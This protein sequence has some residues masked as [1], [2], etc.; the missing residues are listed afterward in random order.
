[1]YTKTESE[2]LED[3][4]NGRLATIEETKYTVTFNSDGGTLIDSQKVIKGEKA[5]EPTI[6]IKEG[7][8]FVGW[9][10]GEEKME[11]YRILCN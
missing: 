2:W 9:F 8:T 5:I 7:Y 6:P 1:M 4:V 10:M 11:L 3:L